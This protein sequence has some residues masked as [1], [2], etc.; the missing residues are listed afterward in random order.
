M[1][2]EEQ[3]KTVPYSERFKGFLNSL[4]AARK[5]AEKTIT[6]FKDRLDRNPIDAFEVGP[7]GG[8][9]GSPDRGVDDHP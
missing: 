9:A 3:K 5:T 7:G 6:T 2:T 8:G 4:D 1:I